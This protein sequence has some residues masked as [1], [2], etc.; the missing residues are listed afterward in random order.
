M[1]NLKELLKSFTKLVIL[2]VVAFSLSVSLT[3]LPVSADTYKQDGKSNQSSLLEQNSGAN[4][5]ENQKRRGQV[6]TQPFY[7]VVQDKSTVVPTPDRILRDTNEQGAHG[8][9]EH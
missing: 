5:V 4:K 9:T 3:T 1:K 7:S 2:Y 8:G 6:Q